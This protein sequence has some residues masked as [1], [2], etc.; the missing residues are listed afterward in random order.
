VS[1][2]V[3][4]IDGKKIKANASLD[5][6]R[7]YREVV[8]E[9]LREA[10]ETDRREDELYGDKHGDELPD[11]LRTREGRRAALRE[12]KRRLAQRKGRA[13]DGSGED[14]PGAGGAVGVDLAVERFVT[15]HGARG[16]WFREARRELENRRALEARPIPRDRDDRLL[17]C[18]RRLEE[19]HQVDLAANQ[20]YEHYRLPGQRAHERLPGG[21][22]A[23]HDSPGSGDFEEGL[24]HEWVAVPFDGHYDAGG[25]VPRGSRRQPV[26][27]C[28]IAMPVEAAVGF[29]ARASACF[30][31][32]MPNVL[33]VC[34][35]R[36]ADVRS[37][38]R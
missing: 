23:A 9:I 10:E 5:N 15:H 18:A 12:A 30:S 14:D 36:S 11:P 24:G 13:I 32:A 37:S 22:R 25:V 8:T 20:A 17:E 6:N 26:T 21:R 35:R 3:I 34:I 2:G 31:P 33:P 1:V 7:S 19:A 28:W 4:M 16:N 29:S 38:P 27:A